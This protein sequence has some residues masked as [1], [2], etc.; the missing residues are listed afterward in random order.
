VG[1]ADA[2]DTETTLREVEPVARA[3]GMQIPVIRASTSSEVETA[4]AAPAGHGAATFELVINLQTARLL[5]IEVPPTVLALATEV[6]ERVRQA[7]LVRSSRWSHNPTQEP[8]A[9]KPHVP[10][11]AGGV[12]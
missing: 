8:Y 4:I 1:P 7:E 3:M 9:G 11:W 5:G 2:R 12:R 10:I 6:I